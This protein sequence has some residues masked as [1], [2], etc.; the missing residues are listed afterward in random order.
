MPEET[1]LVSVLITAYNRE[2]YIA[3]AI[4]SILASTYTNFELIIVDDCSTDATAAIAKEFEK[5]D[6]RVKVYVNEKNLTQFGNRNKAAELAR[7]KY[8]KYIDSDDAIFPDGLAYCVAE[9]EKYPE[10]GI[11]MLLIDTKGIEDAV[12]MGSQKAIKEQFFIRGILSIGPSGSI[13]RRNI[14]NETGGFDIHS[15]VLADTHLNIR[16]VARS[17]VVLLPKV[18]FFYRVHEGQ[19]KSNEELHILS[20]YLYFKDLL[21]NGNLPLAPAEIRYL[22]RKMEKRYAITLTKHFFKRGK[23]EAVKKLMKETNFSFSDILA[24]FFK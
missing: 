7:G 12:Y 23:A 2:K 5:L 1:P 24:G 3:E 18:F 10:A 15:G 17:G 16:I 19:V 8:L 4:S 20:G 6:N 21:E 11:G 14:F 13:I 22:Y 9:M